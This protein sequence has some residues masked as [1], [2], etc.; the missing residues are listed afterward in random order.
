MG[1]FPEPRFAGVW[2]EGSFAGLP[3]DSK[4][5]AVKGDF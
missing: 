5:Y 2:S 3:A 1:H 4:R